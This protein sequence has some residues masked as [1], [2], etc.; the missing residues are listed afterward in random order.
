[1]LGMSLNEVVDE[2]IGGRNAW[3]SGK[4]EM[5]W[6]RRGNLAGMAGRCLRDRKRPERETGRRM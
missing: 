5:F 6:L 3:M 4:D 2:A 1:M